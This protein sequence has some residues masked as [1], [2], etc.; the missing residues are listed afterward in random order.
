[1]VDAEMKKALHEVLNERD[2]LD[3]ATH[4]TDH[5]F[6]AFLRSE[7]QRRD[8]RREKIKTHV[9]GW[10]AVAALGS[11]IAGLGAWVQHFFHAG[12]K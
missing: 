8:E 9:Y 4:R 3:R 2:S 5:E 10:A 1:M 12:G 6:V 7:R 11:F